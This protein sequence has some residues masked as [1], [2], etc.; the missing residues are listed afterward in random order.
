M[1]QTPGN[2]KSTE[3]GKDLMK[4]ISKNPSYFE[5][6][7]DSSNWKESYQ[8]WKEGLA[9]HGQIHTE[10]SLKCVLR[11]SGTQSVL[12]CLKTSAIKIESIQR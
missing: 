6:G 3:E 7:Q 11:T 4:K 2:F 12:T 5:S 9:D 1:M 8:D 10:A